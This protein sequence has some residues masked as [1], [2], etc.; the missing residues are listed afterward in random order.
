MKKL[1]KPSEPLA[2][3]KPVDPA[4][5]I[6]TAAPPAEL[7]P[8]EPQAPPVEIP[9]EAIQVTAGALTQDDPATPATPGSTI[10]PA[11]P[12]PPLVELPPSN[13]A[14][15]LDGWKCKECNKPFN[16]RSR[17]VA[18]IKAVHADKAETLVAEVPPT[19]G[20]GSPTK[21]RNKRADFS[22]VPTAT[23]KPVDYNLVAGMLFTTS[24]GILSMVFGNEWQPRSEE[25]KQAVTGALATYCQSKEV[26][27]IP[28]GV[29]LACVVLAYAAPRLREPNT[30]GK[31]KLTWLWCK[32]KVAPFF[33]RRKKTAELK[34]VT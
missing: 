14:E 30:M 25:E 31:L 19:Y 28:P 12:L 34:V 2:G 32:A 3:E 23:I 20:N 9:A 24:T 6:E 11:T 27:D 7:K 33:S 10:S 22:D 4:T 26:K 29:L 8:V 16:Y 17:L 18:H 15:T 13:E 1:N 21:T 5:T